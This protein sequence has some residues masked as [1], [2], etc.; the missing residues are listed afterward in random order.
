MSF[1]ADDVRGRICVIFDF[2]GT[3][4]D[5]MSRICAKAREILLEYG[6]TDEDIGDIRRIVGPPFPQAFSIIYGLSEEQAAEIAAKYRRSYKDGLGVEAWPCFDGIPEALIKLRSEGC[7]LAVA[8]SKGQ[9]LIDQAID[10][11]AI[12]HLFTAIEGKRS[13]AENDKVKVRLNGYKDKE[14]NAHIKTIST[15]SHDLAEKEDA[16]WDRERR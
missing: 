9:Y 13:D 6:L 16:G 5:T 4:A 12:R 10:D 3:I 7:E 1:T 2:D 11:N 8:S 14:F 15:L